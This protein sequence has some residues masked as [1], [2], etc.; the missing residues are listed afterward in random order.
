MTRNGDR[1]MEF[2]SYYIELARGYQA[3][4]KPDKAAL[5]LANAHKTLDAVVAE[6]YKETEDDDA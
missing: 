2:F 3:A 4:G 6:Y 1:R 5:C